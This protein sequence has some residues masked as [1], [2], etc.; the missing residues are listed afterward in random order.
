M[1]VVVLANLSFH[2]E[3]RGC[4][5]MS[6]TEEALAR[7]LEEDGGLLGVCA[8]VDGRGQA[9]EHGLDRVDGDLG[10]P[11]A[12]NIGDHDFRVNAGLDAGLAAGHLL[13]EP[14]GTGLDAGAVLGRDGDVDAVLAETHDGAILEE[15]EAGEVCG[16]VVDEVDGAERRDEAGGDSLAETALGSRTECEPGRC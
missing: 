10:L 15:G 1:G 5:V 16:I 2:V 13:G 6:T 14:V 11:G 4:D 7:L 3:M 12:R 9:L 8:S